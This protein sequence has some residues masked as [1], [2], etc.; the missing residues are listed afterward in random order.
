MVNGGNLSQQQH[1]NSFIK[2][3]TA[4][5]RLQMILYFRRLD[6]FISLCATIS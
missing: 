3:Y 2:T 4:W 5:L 1:S 6:L